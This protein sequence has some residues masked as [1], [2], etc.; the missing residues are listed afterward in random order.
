MTNISSQTI[1][2]SNFFILLEKFTCQWFL[3]SFNSSIRAVINWWNIQ[4]GFSE[5]IEDR[6]IVT[7]SLNQHCQAEQTIYIA[8]RAALHTALKNIIVRKWTATEA[9]SFVVVVTWSIFCFAAMYE[10]KIFVQGVMWEINSFDQWG[11]VYIFLFNSVCSKK[12]FYRLNLRAMS[13]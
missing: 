13:K 6:C 4:R 7:V 8:L 11:W 9:F 5:D 1:T 12:W 2:N 3:R 10:H